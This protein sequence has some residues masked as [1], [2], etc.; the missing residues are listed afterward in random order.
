M[1]S[2]SGPAELLADLS[3]VLRSRAVTVDLGVASVPFIGP[4]DLVVTKILAGRSKDLDDVAGVRCER[5][6][7]LDLEAIRST[8]TQ[9]QQALGQSDLIVV[10]DA[11]LAQWRRGPGRDNAPASPQR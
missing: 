3:R 8:L 4:E 10:F 5:G 6:A 7:R 11:Q 2:P 1:P 9:L